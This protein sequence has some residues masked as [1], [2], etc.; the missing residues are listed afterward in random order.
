MTTRMAMITTVA[1]LSS[2]TVMTSIP[3]IAIV[4]SNHCSLFL[5][6]VLYSCIV[7]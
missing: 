1:I 6:E 5:H 3:S 7:V 4:N 2:M